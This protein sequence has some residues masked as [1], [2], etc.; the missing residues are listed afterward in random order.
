[1]ATTE[2]VLPTAARLL[3]IELS[4]ASY[5]VLVP[6]A[7]SGA[8]PNLARLIHSAA[9]ARLHCPGPCNASVARATVATGGGPGVHGL[10]DD[11]YV[12]HQQGRIVPSANRPLDCLS[13]GDLVAAQSGRSAVLK[14]ADLPAG[15]VLWKRR[16]AGF[17]ELGRGIARTETVVRRAVEHALE[18][19]RNGNWRLLQLRLDAFDSMLHR[20]WHLLGVGGRPGGNRR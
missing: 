12:D 6:L 4:G 16:P 8:M 2:P 10:L 3:L 7:D 14:V 20:L 9:L 13:L 17:D 5:D 18:L 15:E 19:G 1:M 11:R